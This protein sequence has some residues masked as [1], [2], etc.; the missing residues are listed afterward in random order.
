MI[1]LIEFIDK[2]EG[3]V[4]SSAFLTFGR[5][6]RYGGMHR[7]FYVSLCIPAL[8]MTEYQFD[9]MKDVHGWYGYRVSAGYYVTTDRTVV[10]FFQ[11]FWDLITLI[12]IE[13]PEKKCNG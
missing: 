8:K 4:I 5:W 13:T 10:P 7:G 3:G 2:K 11:T 12:S 1:K 6:H 9:V